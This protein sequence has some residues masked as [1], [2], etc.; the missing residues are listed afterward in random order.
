MILAK[1]VASGVG[2]GRV[3]VGVDMQAMETTFAPSAQQ[4]GIDLQAVA[5]PPI[6][7]AAC[8]LWEDT[9]GPWVAHPVPAALQ[10]STSEPLE[11]ML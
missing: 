1:I 6:V 8:A 5:T 2:G 3:V 10:E 11:I 4:V 7:R 9:K